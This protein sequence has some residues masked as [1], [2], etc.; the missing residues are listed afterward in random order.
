M[1]MINRHPPK[2]LVLL[3]ALLPFFLVFLTYVTAS[4]IRLADNPADKLLPALSSIA[5]AIDRMAFTVNARTDDILM[6]VDTLASL[7]RLAISLAISITLAIVAG[8]AIGLLPYAEACAIANRLPSRRRA[9][10]DTGTHERVGHRSSLRAPWRTGLLRSPG[11]RRSLH[12]AL[13]SAFQ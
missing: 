7:E 1:R 6:L 4:A 5:D 3:L 13:R 10:T 12:V 9:I 11:Y 2:G 8:L